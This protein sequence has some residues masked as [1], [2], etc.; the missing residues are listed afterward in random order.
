VVESFP[1]ED[2]GEVLEAAE[3]KKKGYGL[4]PDQNGIVE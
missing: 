3:Y 2:R 1:A 4:E